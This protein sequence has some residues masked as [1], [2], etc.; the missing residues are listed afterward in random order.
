MIKALQERRHTLTFT[1]CVKCLRGNIIKIYRFVGTECPIERSKV[2]AKGD[3]YLENRYRAQEHCWQFERR[4]LH[5]DRRRSQENVQ[6]QRAP[7]TPQKRASHRSDTFSRSLEGQFAKLLDD[8]R[9]YRRLT[10]KKSIY[11]RTVQCS[12]NGPSSRKGMR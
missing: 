10:R 4:D 8:T 3:S 12:P 5:P 11:P 1:S 9:L 2:G 6:L 7:T